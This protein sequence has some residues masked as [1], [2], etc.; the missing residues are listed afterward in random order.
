MAQPSQDVIKILKLFQIISKFSGM[1]TFCY[2]RKTFK[3][4]F[5]G[6]CFAVFYSISCLLLLFRAVQ[7]LAVNLKRKASV[8]YLLV[9]AVIE[10]NIF[11]LMFTVIWI[12]FFLR[13]RIFRALKMFERFDEV[14]IY[15]LYLADSQKEKKIFFRIIT[16]SRPEN[17]Q[18]SG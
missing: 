8:V 10:L 16:T 14:N 18:I 15:T 13:K 7:A 11:I 2:P 1:S 4:S 9:L 6:L 3:F 5:T 12:N 17:Q